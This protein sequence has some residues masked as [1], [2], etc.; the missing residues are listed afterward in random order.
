MPAISIANLTEQVVREID[1]RLV[2]YRER[3]GRPL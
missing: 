1:R 2:A 3:I